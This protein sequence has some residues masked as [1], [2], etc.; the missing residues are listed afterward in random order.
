VSGFA[1][2]DVPAYV[3]YLIVIVFG[4]FVARARVSSLLQ[5]YED[6]WAFVGT[7]LV[8]FA[9]VVIPI[10]LFWFLDYTDAIHDTSIF[11]PRSPLARPT[12]CS[13]W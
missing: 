6:R 8:F 12:T 5:A 3:S 10:A 9:Y 2:P 4:A 13:D 11:V 1:S 7:W